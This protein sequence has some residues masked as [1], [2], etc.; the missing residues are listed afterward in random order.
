[1]VAAAIFSLIR[2]SLFLLACTRW[3]SLSSSASLGISFGGFSRS[4][5]I[6][7]ILLYVACSIPRWRRGGCRRIL[8]LVLCCLLEVVWYGLRRGCE[9]GL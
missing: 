8:I 4:A 1:M 2:G 9:E 6:V 7:T 3:Y 5:S